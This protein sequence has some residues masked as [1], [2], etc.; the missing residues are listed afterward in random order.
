MLHKI[1]SKVATTN[2]VNAVITFRLRCYQLGN[3][4]AIYLR[5]MYEYFILHLLDEGR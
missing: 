3:P 4:E 5:G 1:L 2:E